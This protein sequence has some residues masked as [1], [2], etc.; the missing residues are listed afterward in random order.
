VDASVGVKWYITETHSGEAARLLGDQFEPHVPS[1]FY[2]ELASTLWKKVVL[3]GELTEDQARG[4]RDAVDAVPV[5][6]HPTA[7]LLDEAFEI[8]LVTRRTVYDCLYVALAERLGC[9]VVTAD[10]K[11]YNATRGGPYA[12]RVHWVEDPI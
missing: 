11:L 8:A 10:E 12:A 7:A 9:L 5:V 6:S 3:R 4:V 2:V 1:H